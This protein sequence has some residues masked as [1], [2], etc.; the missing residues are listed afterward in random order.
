MK[1]REDRENGNFSNRSRILKFQI[2]IKNLFLG[3]TLILCV[4]IQ[5]LLPIFS[6]VCFAFIF[7]V[8]IKITGKYDDTN[9]IELFPIH[10]MNWTYCIAFFGVFFGLNLIRKIFFPSLVDYSFLWIVFFTFLKTILFGL[11]SVGKWKIQ[12]TFLLTFFTDTYGSLFHETYLAKYISNL[13][14]NLF[15]RVIEIYYP[16]FFFYYCFK[17][18]YYLIPAY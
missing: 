9:V 16:F 14:S 10:E 18:V 1:K 12:P 5:F 11:F 3:I 17:L 13:W 4:Q 2:L 15:P 7:Y 8:F 6:L